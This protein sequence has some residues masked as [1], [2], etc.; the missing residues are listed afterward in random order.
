MTLQEAIQ[1][2]RKKE[3]PFDFDDMLAEME[4]SLSSGPSSGS[5][6][7]ILTKR[8]TSPQMQPN[9]S[10]RPRSWSDLR[11]EH[12]AFEAW[13]E[14]R[15]KQIEG[16]KNLKTGSFSVSDPEQGITESPLGDATLLLVVPLE[17]LKRLDGPAC[18]WIGYTP[19]HK[20]FQMLQEAYQRGEWMG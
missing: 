16:I 5:K 9:L 2:C 17:A 13:K 6:P 3:K 8:Y 15:L 4:K 20:G 10:T 19:T 12:E 18:N 14:T 1:I 7:D 11:R